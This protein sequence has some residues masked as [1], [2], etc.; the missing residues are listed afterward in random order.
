[1]GGLG[2]GAVTQPHHGFPDFPQRIAGNRLDIRQF[3]PDTSGIRLEQAL[4]DLGLQRHDGQGVAQ[5]IVQIA[6]DPL[7]LGLYGEGGGACLAF[8][9]LGIPVLAQGRPG[10]GCSDQ[11]AKGQETGRIDQGQ[12][13]K[14]CT[15]HNTQRPGDQTA[16]HQPPLADSGDH[17]GGIDQE[18]GGA[19]ID[20]H[21]H[22]TGHHHPGRRRKR[23]PVAPDHGHEE[24]GQEEAD[25]EQA[26][27]QVRPFR[28]PVEPGQEI[29]DE[30]DQIEPGLVGRGQPQ[31]AAIS[32]FR[33]A[34][35]YAMASALPWMTPS[36]LRR[37]RKISHRM[38]A[39]A[40][41]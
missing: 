6:G 33:L 13:Q 36:F 28:R 10:R 19:R 9:L 3:L 24:Q 35:D 41:R 30:I 1:M 4:G 23:R 14:G 17:G 18:H 39:A 26:G 7:A 37:R 12:S 25:G 29:Q 27:D 38:P 32:R 5:Q 34:H 16:L 20:R 22:E 2:Q 15:G 40:S 21:Q 31:P 8:V 11:T